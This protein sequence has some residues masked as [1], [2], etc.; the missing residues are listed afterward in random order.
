MSTRVEGATVLITVTAHAM[1]S[2]GPAHLVLSARGV[3]TS[4]TA[5]KTA[6]STAGS[7]GKPTTWTFC[8]TRPVSAGT[9]TSRERP[10]EA[11]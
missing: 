7:P 3:T 8:C 6:S 2:A 10:N 9:P 1:L 4:P 5:K 11:C